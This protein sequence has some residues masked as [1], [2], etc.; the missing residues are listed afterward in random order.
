MKNLLRI[1]SSA[2]LVGLASFTAQ[3]Q[4]AVQTTTVAPSMG[5]ITEFSP[6]VLT[7]RTESAAAPV[8]Y[9]YTKSTTYVDEMGNPV[10]IETV[11]SGLPVTVY[12][13]SEGGSM[14]ASKVVVRR[15]AAATTTTVAPAAAVEEHTTTTT[16]TTKKED[17]D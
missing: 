13:T 8:A 6:D 9:H 7:V 12:Y 17:D 2:V 3:A 1:V 15:A 4:T 14:V 11:K 10:S 16:T 5:T